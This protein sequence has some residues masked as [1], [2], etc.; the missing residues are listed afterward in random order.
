M[1]TSFIILRRA[2]LQKALTLPILACDD[3]LLSPL[4]CLCEEE[5]EEVEVE[6]VEQ[7]SIPAPPPSWLRE[8][9]LSQVRFR[10]GSSE[11][12]DR[13]GGS[14]FSSRRRDCFLFRE[15]LNTHRHKN[16]SSFTICLF[17]ITVLNIALLLYINGNLCSNYLNYS[18]AEM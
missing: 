15:L 6:E 11:R 5:E 10:G 12:G 16:N 4:L 13:R 3:A 14:S 1:N 8:E 7:G 9:P 17:N 2:N 18:T